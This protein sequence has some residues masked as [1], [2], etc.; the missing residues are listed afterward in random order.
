VLA[1]RHGSYYP[2]PP[3]A[4]QRHLELPSFAEPEGIR[5]AFEA[6][7]QL[8]ESMTEE[9]EAPAVREKNLANLAEL[10]RLHP[11]MEAHA[12]SVHAWRLL[13]EANAR[14]KRRML[15]ETR[16]LLRQAGERLAQIGTEPLRR[17][18]GSLVTEF[19]RAGGDMDAGSASLAPAPEATTARTVHPQPAPPVEAKAP[20]VEVPST[21]PRARPRLRLPARAAAQAGEAFRLAVTVDH[22]PVRLAMTGLPPGL[23]WQNDGLIRGRPIRAGEFRVTIMAESPAGIDSASFSLSVTPAQV[24]PPPAPP[25]KTPEPPRAPAPT[26]PPLVSTPPPPRSKPAPPPPAAPHPAPSLTVPPPP[27]PPVRPPP[28]PPPPV[29]AAPPPPVAAPPPPTPVPVVAAK[30]EA[31]VVPPPVPVPAPAPIAASAPSSAATPPAPPAPAP[32]PVAPP[33]PPAAPAAVT[34]PPPRAP[35]PPPPEIPPPPPAA[36]TPPPAPVAL[37]PVPAVAPSARAAPAPAVVTPPLPPATPDPALVSPPPP[38]AVAPTTEP[39]A[40][41]AA[42]PP[43]PAFAGDRF[44]LRL[45]HG[46]RLHIFAIPRLRLGRADTCDLHVAALARGNPTRTVAVTREISRKHCEFTLAER[47]AI[48][49]DGSAEDG[50][51]SK[52]GTFVDDLPVPTTGTPVGS[53]QVI[54]ITSQA[55]GADSPHWRAQLADLTALSPVPEM[56][57]ATQASLAQGFALHLTRLD[58]VPDDVLVLRPAADLHTLGITPDRCWLVHEADGFRLIHEGRFEPVSR[59]LRLVP[60]TTL[61]APGTIETHAIEDLVRIAGASR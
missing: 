32:A 27:A 18:H 14:L 23:V 34:P 53:G 4:L 22:G 24:A 12:E 40:A 21:S 25:P 26:T 55:A 30:P 48:L 35:S 13:G 10:K 46:R 3:P 60:G 20:S 50:K 33:P 2:A 44:T 56:S 54:R 11:A 42:A 52:Y 37:P 7:C 5:N 28:P 9:D 36:V 15:D 61:S 1:A 16:T 41:I 49:R 59:L 6:W 38:P 29:R 17:W 51:P 43:P 8:Y 45:P 47:G 58:A 31:A 39:A 19:T 57:P